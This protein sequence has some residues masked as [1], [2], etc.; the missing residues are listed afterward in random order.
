MDFLHHVMEH[1]F[2]MYFPKPIQGLLLAY[3]LFK[4]LDFFTGLLKT[5][6]KVSPYS[7]RIMRDGI[8]RWI[9][10]VLAIVFVIAIDFFLGLNFYLSGATLALFV[11][12]EGGSIA[13][14]LKKL[15]VDMPGIL[16]E[17][18]RDKVEQ[19]VKER[20]KKGGK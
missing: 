7:S 11:Y 17:I 6:K 1:P 15:G 10:E 13:E 20:M 14:N 18:D 16:S 4:A 19:A 2:I 5:W 3:F 12:K 8:V 9:G